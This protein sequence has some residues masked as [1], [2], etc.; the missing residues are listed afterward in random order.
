MSEA[1]LRQ[2]CEMDGLYEFAELN[3]KIYLHYKVVER[4]SGLD[5]YV[6]LKSIY[7]E[8]NVITRIEGLD[9]LQNLENLFLHNNMIKR[10]ENL[11]RLKQLRVLNLS[12]NSIFAVEGLSELVQLQSLTLSKNFL[13]LFPSLEHL[14]QC[15]PTLTSIDLTDN[16]IEADDRL[17]GLLP[18]VRCLY[19]S[20]NP[21]VRE[22][23]HY[24]RTVVGR[25]AQL[26]YL[27]QRAVDAEE[28][29][30][31]EAWV[32]EGE[33]G[34]R[35]ARE[36]ILA[37]R[38]Q[39]KQEQREEI[40]KNID[41]HRRNKI[42]VFESNI[43]EAEKEIRKL[44]EY[45]R[46]PANE[47]QLFFYENRVGELVQRIMDNQQFIDSLYRRM[48]LEPLPPVAT[49]NLPDRPTAPQDRPNNGEIFEIRESRE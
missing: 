17:F 12:G 8:N 9:A 13:A 48:G 44:Q 2:I 15:S 20:G 42:N 1:N 26:L 19:L 35:R 10:I 31:A 39:R 47:S 43:L 23:T 4:I 25:L 16:K 22:V 5:Q 49:I 33:A 29:I 27:D 40:M 38:R 34:F 7:L 11:D 14:G 37:F 21:L 6:G 32:R 36:G 24:R 46:D 18:Q 28:R 3:K 41:V 45:M 30:V